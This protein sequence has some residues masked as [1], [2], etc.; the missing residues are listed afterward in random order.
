MTITLDVDTLHIEI[1][2]PNSGLAL[3]LSAPIV[4]IIH[5]D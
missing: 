3:K 4:A 5:E 1:A 2:I